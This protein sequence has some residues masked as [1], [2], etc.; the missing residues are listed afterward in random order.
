MNNKTYRILDYISIALI[1]ITI[2]IIS[3]GITALTLTRNY[4]FY[5]YVQ[6]TYNIKDKLAYSYLDEVNNVWIDVEFTDEDIEVI[7]NSVI[8]YLSD[9]KD[10]LQVYI[11]DKEVFSIQA[12]NHMEDVKGLYHVG[13]WIVNV[14]IILFVISLIYLII[15]IK[16]KYITNEIYKI[17]SL[18][19]KIVLTIGVT[20]IILMII[21]FQFVFTW[22]HML[23]F[24]NYQTFRDAFFTYRSVYD[25]LPY[26]SNVVLTSI[27]SDELFIHAGI[28]IIISIILSYGI[29]FI[30]GLFINKKA[31]RV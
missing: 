30:F 12:I 28:Y 26:V 7:T 5:K 24:P 15:R 13:E 31:K 27:L 19:L 29:W 10:N 16:N 6:S 11:N 3:I 9:N 2:L 25:E 17:S 18:I 21:D 1:S 8:D 22:F 20:L 23:L 4:N 14:S